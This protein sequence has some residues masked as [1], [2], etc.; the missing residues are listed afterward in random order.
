MN[1]K[2]LWLTFFIIVATFGAIR[3]IWMGLSL[4]H[5]RIYDRDLFILCDETSFFKPEI[6]DQIQYTLNAHI[7]LKTFNSLTELEQTLLSAPEYSLIFGPRQVLTTLNKQNWLEN[8]DTQI[9]QY[10]TQDFINFNTY[11]LS[12]FFPVYWHFYVFTQSE[13]P[14][15]KQSLYLPNDI[16][17]I[18]SYFKIQNPVENLDQQ[19]PYEL[20]AKYNIKTINAEVP[21]DA[22]Q[23]KSH[24]EV[25]SGPDLYTNTK[26]Q[27]YLKEYGFSIIRD[28][29]NRGLSYAFIKEYIRKNY[30]TVLLQ[31]L[32]YASTLTEIQSLKIEDSKKPDFIR[33]EIPLTHLHR[34]EKAPVEWE[35]LFKE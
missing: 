26:D 15:P 4:D 21:P 27:I 1:K 28:K 8:I 9:N 17:L 10:I 32:P 34:I 18:Y 23:Y 6:L 30:Q 24:I 13:K 22:S 14:N 12:Y 7:H 5:D 11:N 25:R 35:E 29:E 20:F 19:N 16:D 33:K 3:G 2:I 31:Q